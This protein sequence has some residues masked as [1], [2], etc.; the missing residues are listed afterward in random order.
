VQQ[1]AWWFDDPERVTTKL[2]GVFEG[3]GAKGVA[4]AGALEVVLEKGCWFSA[5]AGSSAG[6]ITA[7]LIAAGLEP[8]DI[9]RETPEG[10]KTLSVRWRKWWRALQGK[11]PYASSGLSNWLEGIL[12]TQVARVR[13]VESPVT[14][15]DLYE[16]THIELN[17]VAV[18]VAQQSPIVFSH[19]DTP[20]CGVVQAVIAS[21]ALPGAFK[22]PAFHAPSFERPHL[23]CD[24]GVWSNFPRFVFT[25]ASFRKLRRGDEAVSVPVVGFVLDE[26]DK[27]RDEADWGNLKWE[28]KR[29][30]LEKQPGKLWDRLAFSPLPYPKLKSWW[31]KALLG[32]A[33]YLMTYRFYWILAWDPLPAADS[34]YGAVWRHPS[35]RLAFCSTV[36][37]DTARWPRGFRRLCRLDP[38]RFDGRV[39]FDAAARV[40]CLPRR[41]AGNPSIGSQ[42]WSPDVAWPRRQRLRDSTSDRCEARLDHHV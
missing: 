32:P 4:Y 20:E 15:D 21:A 9:K 38:W 34:G 30:T 17:V 27:P 41:M 12:C 42:P 2:A 36:G 10:L 29:E 11:G 35:S 3:G 25:D 1:T 26:S 31:L 40:E 18:D 23:V 13:S 14:F 7:A 24:G 33:L 16:A 39:R 28:P 5:V 37:V 8:E 19:H 22:I 6:A